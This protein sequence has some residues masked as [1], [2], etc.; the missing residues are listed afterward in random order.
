MDSLLGTARCT[1]LALL[2]SASA[3]LGLQHAAIGGSDLPGPIPAELVRV[4]DGDTI[5]VR[6]RIWLDID[7]TTR[8]RLAGV[9]APEIDGACDLERRRARAARR[10]VETWIGE[11]A[12]VALHD[13]RRDKYGGRVVADVIATGGDDLAQALLTARLAHSIGTDPGRWCR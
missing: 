4:I 2:S 11:H 6:A 3:F 7:V 13:I 12:P 10:F 1:C 5:E 8:V 9:D